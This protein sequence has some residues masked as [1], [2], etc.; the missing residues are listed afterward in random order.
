MG[1]KE[2]RAIATL[3]SRKAKQKAA[4]EAIDIA[5]REAV[6]AAFEA[7]DTGGPIAEA[8]GLTPPRV[9]QIRDSRR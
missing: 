2:L 4:Y 7:G 1:A 3:A 9:Y 8:A 6:R 5:L